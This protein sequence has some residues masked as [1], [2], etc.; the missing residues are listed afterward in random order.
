MSFD[1]ILSLFLD[2]KSLSVALLEVIDVKK[3]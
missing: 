3:S 2:I 1:D